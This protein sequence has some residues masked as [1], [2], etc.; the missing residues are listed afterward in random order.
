MV[1]FSLPSALLLNT[2][3]LCLPPG[4]R[5]QAL[6]HELDRVTVG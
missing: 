5:L 4:Q 2:L 1:S 6:A 3:M